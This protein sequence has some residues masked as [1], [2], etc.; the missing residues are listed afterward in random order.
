[1]KNALKVFC[2][3]T[4]R[5]VLIITGFST[6]LLV[7]CINGVKKPY[8]APLIT[9]RNYPHWSLSLGCGTIYFRDLNFVANMLTVGQNEKSPTALLCASSPCADV[10]SGPVSN[11]DGFRIPGI[12]LF[13]EISCPS[14][15]ALQSLSLSL[16]WPLC[17]RIT[18]LKLYTSNF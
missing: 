12:T 13:D 17:L 4:V 8:T 2:V 18:A 14:R 7:A 10:A 16:W 11:F 9:V 15:E 6:Y 5:V 3:N 1:M